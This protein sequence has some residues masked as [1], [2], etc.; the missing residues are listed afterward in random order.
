MKR[1]TAACSFK[2]EGCSRK[3]ESGIS[4]PGA[5]CGP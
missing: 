3:H 2:P 5:R 1:S 4:D